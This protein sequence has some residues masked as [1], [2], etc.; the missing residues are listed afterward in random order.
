MVQVMEAHNQRPGGEMINSRLSFGLNR[1]KTSPTTLTL[2]KNKPTA[3]ISL[4][5][6]YIRSLPLMPPTMSVM[7][8]GSQHSLPVHNHRPA[9]QQRR[10]SQTLEE[11]RNFFESIRSDPNFQVAEEIFNETTEL[12]SQLQSKEKELDQVKTEVSTQLREKQIAIAQM[13]EA[14]EGEK[15]KQREAASEIESLKKLIQEGKDTIAQKESAIS[16]SEDRYNKLQSSK[17]QLES[18]LK[19]SQG[20]I[21]SLQQ[22]LKEKDGLL[23]KIKS[24]HSD[25]QKRLK[26]AEGRAKEAQREKSVLTTSLQATKAQLGRIHGY[27]TE[28]FDS[29]DDDM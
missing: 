9:P 2:W 18:A 7:P 27:T 4:L 26:D 20:D 13:F 1:I 22:K 24:S 12:Q 23:D 10:G 17:S 25:N 14:N 15:S 8:A 19:I 11:L 21:N 29:N 16:H 28:Q 5:C 6:T 3:K